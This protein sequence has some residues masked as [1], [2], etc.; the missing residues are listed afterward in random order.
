MDPSKGGGLYID[1]LLHD[2]DIA[3]YFMGDE[4]ALV[5]ADETNMVVDGEGVHR[6]ADNVVVNLRF[7]GGALATYHASMHA[8]YGYD[9]RS[10]VF[11]SNG[12]LIVGGLHK[13]EVTLCSK[14]KGITYPRTFRQEG[15]LPFFMVR[16]REA[17]EIE[18]QEFVQAVLEDTPVKADVNDAIQAFKIALAATDAGAQSG[19]ISPDTY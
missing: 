9:I 11:G 3:R 17:Y 19:G 7:A 13:T 2:F 8:E 15:R 5:N 16:F 4:V 6:F 18:L 1:M 10:E 14:E 12:N